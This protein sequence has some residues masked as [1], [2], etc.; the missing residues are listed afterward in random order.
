[1]FSP[2]PRRRSAGLVI[3]ALIVALAAMQPSLVAAEPAAAPAAVPPPSGGRVERSAG[4]MIGGSIGLG[5]ETVGLDLRIGAL[6]HPHVAVFGNAMGIASVGGGGR[7]LGGGVRVSSDWLFLDGRYGQIRW[8]YSCDFD[9][10][11]TSTTAG[12]G[13]VSA[14]L[15]LLHGAH[16]GLELHVDL[17]FAFHTVTTE[18]GL[19]VSFYL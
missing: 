15:E 16:A 4:V 5:S 19:G 1:M 17:I 14:G 10:P 18:T 12:A 9:E 2:A 13:V 8:S 11:C 6:V 3:V 7:F